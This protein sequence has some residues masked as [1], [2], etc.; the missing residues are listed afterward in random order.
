MNG[1]VR[2]IGPGKEDN[3]SEFSLDD[4]WAEIDRYNGLE[5]K[6]EQENIKNIKLKQQLD[7]RNFLRQ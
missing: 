2:N 6:K 7:M 1:I 4:E 5:Y 3:L